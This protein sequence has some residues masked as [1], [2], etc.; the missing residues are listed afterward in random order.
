MNVETKYQLKRKAEDKYTKAVG[1]L[2]VVEYLLLPDQQEEQREFALG[3]GKEAIELYERI[4]VN[5]LEDA[6]PTRMRVNGIELPDIMH[7]D[8]VKERLRL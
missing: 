4:G 7:Q 3:L 1:G 6:A 5:T 8:V 2:D